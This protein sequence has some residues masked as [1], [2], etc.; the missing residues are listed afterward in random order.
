MGY[1]VIK[2]TGDV[3]ET[4]FIDK[5]EEL[6]EFDDINEN[7][8]IYEADAQWKLSKIQDYKDLSKYLKDSTRIGN[9]GQKKFKEIMCGK[10]ILCEPI[11]QSKENF[12]IY[13]TLAE[14]EHIKRGDFLL[15]KL[16][17]EVEVKVRTFYTKAD[18]EYFT[19]LYSEIQSLK[20]MMK[21][22]STDIIFA[23]FQRIEQD[24]KDDL[25]YI[26]VDDILTLN[27]QQKLVYNKDK[28]YLE[29]PTSVCAKRF[30]DIL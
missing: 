3:I 12:L 15:R 22:T 24:I 27:N 26:K 6:I 7:T 14:G 17:L 11:D 30:E 18:Y 28:K 4:F 9:L 2:N 5:P 25:I 23:V 10:H 29:I 13:T 19:L 21:T 16:N 20:R 1:H 8:L